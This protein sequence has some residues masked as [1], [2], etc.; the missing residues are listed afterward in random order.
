M[1]VPLCEHFHS[2]PSQ[3]ARRMGHPQCYLRQ[4][5]QKPGPPA[6]KGR[7]MGSPAHSMGLGTA[8]PNE[9]THARDGRGIPPFNKRRVGHPANISTPTLRKV[10]EGLI[11]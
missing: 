3:S 7:M 1:F 10:R 4:R 9:K 5:D 11:G 6:G 2:H 8:G